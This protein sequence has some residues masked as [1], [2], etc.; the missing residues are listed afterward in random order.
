MVEQHAIHW[1]C[2][3][4][5]G[6]IPSF[7][8]TNATTAPV[9]ATITVTPSANGCTGPVFTFTITVQPT[10]TVNPVSNVAYCNGA[11]TTAINFG[12]P[13][14]GTTFAWTNSAP[15]IGL[16]ANGTGNIPSFVAI[17]AGTAPVIATITVTPSANGCV[18]TPLT[19]T[20]TVNPTPNVNT[21][22]NAV[23]CNGVTTAVI[24][25]SGNVAG[26]T[27]AWT[28]N[29]PSIGLAA[30]GTG[31]IPSFTATN[32][33][34][35][36][37]IATITVTPS[38]NGCT[39]TPT[40]FTITVNPTPTVSPI[41]NAA[42]CNG[43]TTTPITIS[44]PV[45]GT[46]FAWTNSAPS[47]GLA[48]SG[49]G[50]IPSFTA[51]NTGT[52]PVVATITVTPTAN[53]CTGTVLTFTITVNPIPT[54]NVVANVAYCNGATT[55]PIVFGSPVAGTTYAWTNST[56]S[57]GLAA[58]GTGNI[59][60]FTATNA[61]TAPVV[62]TITVTPTFSGCTGTPITF[63][64]TVNPTPTVAAVSNVGYCNGATTAPITFTGPVAGTTFAW[65]NSQPSIGLA[66]SG[67]G[68]I[69]SFTATNTGTTPIV[70]TIT[71]TPSANGCNGTPLTFTI[72]VNPILQPTITGYANM[73]INIG[74]L[75]Y[76]TE[77]GMTNYVWTVS[78]GNQISGGNTNQAQITWLV[79]GAQWVKVT[80]TNTYGC[81][82]ANPTTLNVYVEPLP[83]A[84][85]T[86][87]GPAAVCAGQTG[88]SYSVGTITN[89]TSY[90][91]TLP[92]GA[93]VA[94]GDG[95]NAITVDF[96]A[97]ATSGNITV[98]GNNVC[99][100]GTVSPALAVTVGALPETPGL[101][102]GPA[103]VCQGVSGIIYSI[104]ALPS[105]TGYVWTVP[106][107]A[108]IVGPI[109]NSIT[110]DYSTT[111]S[112]GNVTVY[113]TNGCG[114]GQ[115]GPALNVTVNPIPPAP[116]VTI[117]DDTILHSSA[118]S[119]NQWYYEGAPIA[120]ATQQ[121]YEPNKSGWYW[122]VVTINGCS[123]D[124]S[125]HQYFIVIGLETMPS[126]TSFNVYPVP[127][128]GQF[129][130]SISTPTV[131]TYTIKVYNNLGMVIRE[132]KNVEVN[133]TTER[134]I[135]L[136]PTPS[137]LYSVVIENGDKRMIKKILINR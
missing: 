99:G 95:T 132:I 19:F 41:A 98:Y 30:S 92:T 93:T 125:N 35:T 104:A 70:A 134:S 90:V 21:V 120:G 82:P 60:A 78:P 121:D 12:S 39:G 2:S 65:T 27:F 67:T 136:R 129:R 24:T 100:N 79:S 18:G 66:A 72:T 128:D 96:G 10:T 55:A 16:A 130:V 87:S 17:N 84:A 77:A 49:T 15:S 14:A 62:A 122:C 68:N 22:A 57:I 74:P 108:T 47:I 103:S 63:T 114:N 91:W 59:P 56:P 112:S 51:T 9:V 113:G 89:A 86:I 26:T 107:G 117:V 116:V 105:A 32:A 34:T 38:A 43:A 73:C 40:T 124:T 45:A 69:P 13:V 46:T 127:N 54:V 31:N 53:G 61:T 83:G 106:P 137:G 85:G 50:N 11:T 25:F 109:S 7:V 119:G 133:G 44:G 88:V 3:K 29:T 42:Y 58:S 123:S 102:S 64:I 131:E 71:V 118:P 36:P 8:A 33:G 28:N 80:Y 94:S 75:S 111:A 37:V 6:N 110:V 76:T 101:I 97:N 52:S 48:A 5:S 115:T 81:S 135:D 1:P 20:I 23:Y 126:S 4:W